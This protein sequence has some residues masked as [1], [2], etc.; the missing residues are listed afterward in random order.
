MSE[1]SR[2]KMSQSHMGN[3]SRLGIKH[4]ED[5][6]LRMSNSHKGK[7]LSELHRKSIGLSQIGR[8]HTAKSLEKMRLIKLGNSYNLGKKVPY[9][10]RI[11]RMGIN[12]PLWKG[13]YNSLPDK[14]RRL[15]EYRQWRSDVFTRDDYTCQECGFMGYIEADHIKSFRTIINE[16]NIETVEGALLCSELWDINNGRTL[17]SPC[18][19]NTDNYGSKLV[20]KK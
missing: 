20:W 18:H 5:V 12:H 9:E 8:K 16:Y 2:L 14:I 15:Y 3:K 7:P 6:K 19:K 17:C 1:E 10:K 13:G 11:K 4:R